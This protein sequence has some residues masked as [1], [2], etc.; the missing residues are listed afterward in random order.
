MKKLNGTGV[1]L[2]TPFKQNLDI[3]FDA[4]LKIIQ[5]ILLSNINYVVINGTTGESATTSV[6]EKNLIIEYVKLKNHK[7]L[8]LVLGIG[9]CNTTMVI[10]QISETNLDGISAILS[11]S[12]YYNKPSQEGIYEHY[13]KIANFSPVPIILYNVPSRTGTNID[14]KTVLSLSQHHNIIGIKESSTNLMQSI[15]I[16]SYKPNDFLLISGDDMLTIP[17]ISIGGCGVIS[18]LANCFPQQI[19]NM[20]ESASSANYQ[21]ANN[22]A[23]S[24]LPLNEVVEEYGNPVGIKL[25]LNSLGLCSNY[26]RMPLFQTECNITEEKIKNYLLKM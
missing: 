3:D 19:S 12:P 6:E 25:I 23:S 10:K 11:V 17:R 18:A 8:P 15:Y 5:N 21:L 4:L 13:I 26:V 16:A 2:V 9:G 14:A 1:A 20:I 7:K 22:I 24:L